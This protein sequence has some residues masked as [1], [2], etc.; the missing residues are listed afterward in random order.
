MQDN[1]TSLEK[2]ILESDEKKSKDAQERFANA[3][4]D[5]PRTRKYMEDS[6]KWA[7]ETLKA[8]EKVQATIVQRSGPSPRHKGME[9]SCRLFI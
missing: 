5:V 3:E 6:H 1:M 4:E 8:V 9:E 7:Q 2:Q